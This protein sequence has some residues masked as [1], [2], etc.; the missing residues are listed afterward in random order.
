MVT[1]SCRR[2]TWPGAWRRSDARG[3]GARVGA[4]LIDPAL[5]TGLVAFLATFAVAY[6]LVFNLTGFRSHVDLLLGPASQRYRMY[7]NSLAGHVAM[8]ATALDLLPWCLGWPAFL[9]CVGGVLLLVLRRATLPLAGLS[10][11]IVS[12]Y[13]FV[14]SVVGYHY[15][16]FFLGLCLSLAIVSGYAL[17]WVHGRY[18]QAGAFLARGVLAFSIVN[19]ASVPVLMWADSRYY[20]ER[21]LAERYPRGDYGAF[22]GR[23]EYLPRL[24]RYQVMEVEANSDSLTSWGATFLVTN[25]AFSLRSHGD[26]V[27]WQFYLDLKAGRLGYRRVLAHRTRIFTL[28]GLNHRISSAQANPFTNLN[29]INPEIR[30]YERINPPDAGIGPGAGAAQ[31]LTTPVR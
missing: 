13:A 18:R 23:P 19:G 30:V 31:N 15:D 11:P 21:W 7:D 25:W 1:S 26:D 5:W 20:V 8:A 12:Y 27:R 28:L 17:A 10:V 22:I 9:A 2:S 3:L 14:V 24:T 16:R 6:N 4:V 29:K